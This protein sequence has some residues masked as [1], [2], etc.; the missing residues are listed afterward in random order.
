LTDRTILKDR[1]AKPLIEDLRRLPNQQNLTHKA[2]VEIE[3]VKDAEI[4]FVDG[5]PIAFRKKGELIP[6]LTN[7]VALD[8]MPRI[9]VDMG[10]VPH[11][12]GGADIMAPGIRNISES[13]LEK[14]LVVVVDEKHGKYLAVGKALLDAGPMR[15]TKHGKVVSNV[16]YVG[17]PIWEA[18]KPK[19]PGS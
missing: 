17:D 2:R 3:T 6:V 13:V 15:T 19:G 16:H 12:A 9:V 18:I 5:V 8:S 7:K 4:I 1:D 14:N 11:V 10:A